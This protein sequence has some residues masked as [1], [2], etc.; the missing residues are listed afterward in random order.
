MQQDLTDKP[1]VVQTHAFGMKAEDG[2]AK[3]EVHIGLLNDG[4]YRIRLVTNWEG[5][6][7]PVTTDIALS[8][9]GFSLFTS[10]VMEAS[11]NMQNWPT[12]D[13]STPEK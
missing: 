4:S 3:R 1:A 9:A 11:L 7:E 8:S 13:T 12:P 2:V 6:D 10:A 5:K